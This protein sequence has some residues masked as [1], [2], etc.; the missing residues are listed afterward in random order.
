MGKYAEEI[1]RYK[2][3]LEAME[4]LEV[5]SNNNAHTS[6]QLQ[7]MVEAYQKQIAHLEAELIQKERAIVEARSYADTAF[8]L[9]N[10][11]KDS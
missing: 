3:K 10:R 9:E 8:V 11:L 4:K 7:A 1:K 2:S 5:V 6:Q